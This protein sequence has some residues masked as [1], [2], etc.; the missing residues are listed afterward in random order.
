MA[1]ATLE[2]LE[3]HLGRADDGRMQSVLAAALAWCHRMRP[4]LSPAGQVDAAVS[5]AVVIYAGLMWRSRSNPSGF[6][7]YTETDSGLG[8]AYNAMA[9]VYRLLGARRPVAR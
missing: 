8:D 3:A 1:W 2:Q 9:N 4:D 6:D 5:E 7:T